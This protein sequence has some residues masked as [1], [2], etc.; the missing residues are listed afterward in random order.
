M[1][2]CLH[3]FNELSDKVDEANHHL[4]DNMTE[5]SMT[6]ENICIKPN[7][8]FDHFLELK[9]SWEKIF[10]EFINRPDR[11]NELV[12]TLVK[13]AHGTINELDTNPFGKDNL[14]YLLMLF[15]DIWHIKKNSL[16]WIKISEKRWHLF[17]RS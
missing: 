15:Y 10:D 9:T 17:S 1:T 14:N 16:S 6:Y 4:I 8:T 12:G 11:C 3:I 5:P 13:T 7:L 2:N